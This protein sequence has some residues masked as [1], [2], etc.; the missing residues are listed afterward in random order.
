MI[1][2]LVMSYPSYVADL[3]L[4]YTFK[5]HVF[6]LYSIYVYVNVLACFFMNVFYNTKSNVWHFTGFSHTLV[7]FYLYLKM[8]HWVL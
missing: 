2:F 4:C 8:F 7:H 5:I 6:K 3:L 1:V